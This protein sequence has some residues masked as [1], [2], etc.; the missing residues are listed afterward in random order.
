MNNSMWGLV[1]FTTKQTIM[2]YAMVLLLYY[3][4]Y[5]Y[6]VIILT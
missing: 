1:L 2:R 6:L 3:N 4:K 5:K